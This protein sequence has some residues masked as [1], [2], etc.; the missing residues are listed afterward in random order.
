MHLKLDLNALRITTLTV[1]FCLAVSG[2]SSDDP[3]GP[4]TQA[5]DLGSLV[6][7]AEVTEFDIVGATTT[8]VPTLTNADGVIIVSPQVSFTSSD[9]SVV[10]VDAAGVV[11]ALWPGTA[12][13]GAS[14]GGVEAS[15]EF[16]VTITGPEGPPILGGVVP[17]TGGM[18]GPFPCDNMDLLAYM[19]NGA[20]GVLPGQRINDLWGWTDPATGKEYA[21]V[22]QDG[23]LIFVDVSDPLRP[24]AVGV[25]PGAGRDVKVYKNNAFVIGDGANGVQIFDLTVLRSVTTFTTFSAHLRY[26]ETLYGHNI[27]INEATGF[28][29]VVGGDTCGGGLH[30]IDVSSPSAPSFAGCYAEAGW[31]H[32]V[33]CVLYDGPDMDYAGQEICVASNV[34]FLAVTDVSDK[35]SPVSIA[36]ATY[37]DARYIHQGWFTEDRRYFFQNDELDDHVSTTTRTLIWDMV[38]LD[39]PVMVHEYFGPTTATDHNL[40][41]HGSRAYLSNYTAGLQV[42]DVTNPLNPTEIAFFDTFPANNDRGFRDGSWSNYPFFESGTIIVSSRSEGLF[43]VRLQP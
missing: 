42:L 5:P 1:G 3:T 11:T 18:A 17:C 13:V 6:L 38:D 40:Y 26:T 23:G 22:G 37:S 8:I 43:V 25:L 12:R 32:D 28:A 24:R 16:T 31:T 29:Y 33:Q 27:A 34:S 2:C 20:M 15:L 39:N 4:A 30:M 21:L 10:H 36:I 9:P 41:V 35:A 7:E 14:A 19:P